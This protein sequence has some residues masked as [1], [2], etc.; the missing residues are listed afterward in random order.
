MVLFSKDG[1]VAVFKTFDSQEDGVTRF[2]SHTAVNV[3]DQQP[4]APASESHDLFTL[5][6]IF[7]KK[8]RALISILSL[9]G[10]SGC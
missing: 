3:V 5:H 1:E 8:I 2:T 7:H 9:A 10:A 4:D 6:V